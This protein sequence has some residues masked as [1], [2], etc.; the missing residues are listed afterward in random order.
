MQI[1]SLSDTTQIRALREPVPSHPL[2][3]EQLLPPSLFLFLVVS[4]FQLPSP[5]S[6]FCSLPCSLFDWL[7]SQQTRHIFCFLAQRIFSVLC[8]AQ[9][10]VASPALP[11]DSA[12]PS[13]GEQ[14]ESGLRRDLHLLTAEHSVGTESINK[15]HQTQFSK[16]V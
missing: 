13:P 1:S 9:A 4:H 11:K 5:G 6:V 8:H 10:P 7:T 3:T 16:R 15:L 12:S 14:Q 2:L